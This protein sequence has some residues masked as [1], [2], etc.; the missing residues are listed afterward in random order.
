MIN[1]G[2][3]MDVIDILEKLVSFNTVRDYENKQILD[4]IEETLKSIGFQTE[5]KKRYLIMSYGKNP[6]LAFIG[7]TDTVEYI[8]SWET[9]P[10]KLT[11][12]D[13]KLYGLGCC[14]MKSGIAAFIKALMEI[15]LKKLH[16][17]IKVYFTFSEEQNFEGIK[18]VI[19]SGETLPE[20]ILVGEPTGNIIVT[21]CKGL[22]AYELNFKGIKVHSSNPEKGKSANSSCINFLVE[23]EKFYNDNI[24]PDKNPKYEISYTTMNIGVINGGS[25]INS[26]S[27]NCKATLDFR[28]A[29]DEHIGILKNK[30]DELSKKYDCELCILQEIKSW[31]NKIPFANS[32]YTANYFTEASFIN[33]KRMILGAG[34]V[35]AHEV[36]EHITIDSLKKLTEQYKEIIKEVCE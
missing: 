5:C 15:D 29:K 30:I 34:P 10:F 27:A 17:G 1:K 19:S 28:I 14:D 18:E 2:G 12:K 7:H 33:G 25:A 21:G 6:K 9:D 11:K 24:K 22:L 8:N 35:T 23:L 36:N 32:D 4:Y 26:V 3:K 20:Y 31:Y 16:N 13:D